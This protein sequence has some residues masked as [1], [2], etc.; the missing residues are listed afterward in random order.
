VIIEVLSIYDLF[1]F[2]AEFFRRLTAI[3]IN[4]DDGAGEGVWSIIAF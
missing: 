1:G 2:H 3:H 4:K